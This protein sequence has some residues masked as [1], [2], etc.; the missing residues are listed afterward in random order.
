MMQK[1]CEAHKK[2]SILR[3]VLCDPAWNKFSEFKLSR[4]VWNES[5]VDVR[6][7]YWALEAR[8]GG[9]VGGAKKEKRHFISADSLYGWMVLISY[10]SK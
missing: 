3:Q 5:L 6:N 7:G 10:V 8:F 2:R 9:Q 1:G 4:F